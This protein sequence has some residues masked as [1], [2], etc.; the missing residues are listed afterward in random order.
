VSEQ[1]VVLILARL[2][3]EQVDGIASQQDHRDTKQNRGQVD[4][5][6]VA[7]EHVALACE[8]DQAELGPLFGREHGIA[9][10]RVTLAL[11]T[12]HLAGPL[13]ERKRFV[14]AARQ[15]R[16]YHRPRDDRVNLGL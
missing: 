12:V 5:L 4:T 8:P 1:F 16:G 9:L 13:H 6:S 15:L 7:T 11:I 3:V 10:A 2:T 14:R